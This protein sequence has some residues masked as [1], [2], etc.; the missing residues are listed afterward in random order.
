VVKE[1]KESKDEVKD[2]SERNARRAELE[3]R[4]LRTASGNRFLDRVREIGRPR[5]LREEPPEGE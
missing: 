4:I 3:E 2:F 5:P 1:P